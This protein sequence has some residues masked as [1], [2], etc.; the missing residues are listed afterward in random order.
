MATPKDS[1][2]GGAAAATAAP[3]PPLPRDLRPARAAI[4]DLLH[5][6]THDDGSFGPLFIRLAWPVHR[7]AYIILILPMLLV[8]PPQSIRVMEHA[9]AI[10]PRDGTHT[11]FDAR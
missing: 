10:S 9:L 7:T 5:D 11:A 2:G 3:A 4:A 8:H 1:G 6:R